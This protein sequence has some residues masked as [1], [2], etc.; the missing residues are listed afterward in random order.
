MKPV[1]RQPSPGKQ[2][3]GK[4]K[5]QIKGKDNPYPVCQH[6][7]Y[8]RKEKTACRPAH[9]FPLCGHTVYEGIKK[10]GKGNEQELYTGAGSG[11]EEPEGMVYIPGSGFV[12]KRN[13][14][15]DPDPPCGGGQ[16][17]SEIR[18]SG[19]AV[20]IFYPKKKEEAGQIEYPVFLYHGFDV[21]YCHACSLPRLQVSFFPPDTRYSGA[22]P[23]P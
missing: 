3:P 1:R 4:G 19:S 5:G 7:I 2:L 11:N 6:R 8:I 20:K 12:Y 10:R 14:A 18:N 9:L 16:D 21:S 15:Q 23:R 13:P 22:I 17:P